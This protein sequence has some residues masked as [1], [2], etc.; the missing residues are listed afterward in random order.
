MNKHPHEEVILAYYRGEQIEWRFN[1]GEAWR[2]LDLYGF[3]H[4]NSSGPESFAPH[5]QYRIKPITH[6]VELTREE[7]ETL[8]CLANRVGG[9]KGTARKHSDSARTKLQGLVSDERLYVLYEWRAK[10]G[11]IDGAISFRG[12]LPK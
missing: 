7:V 4:M 12:D 2:P 8:I 1:D 10:E 3:G 9:P 6:T 5:I 11:M